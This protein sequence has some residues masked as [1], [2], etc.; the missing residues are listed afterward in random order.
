MIGGWICVALLLE[1]G[2]G[3]NMD[4]EVGRYIFVSST[5]LSPRVLGGKLWKIFQK[6]PCN[7]ISLL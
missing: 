6:G 3:L 1:R 4:M 5:S 7:F 2:T